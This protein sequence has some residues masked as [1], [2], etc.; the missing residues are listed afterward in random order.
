[1]N[2]V[3][4]P[5]LSLAHH[6]WKQHVQPTDFAMDM[7]CG[8][9]R[10]MA[11]L[12]HLLKQGLVYGLDIQAIALQK[13]KEF[14][15]HQ[16]IHEQ[17]YGLFLQSHAVPIEIPVPPR[18][19]VYNLGYLPGG[20]KSIVTT[21]ETTL[22]S[23][24]QSVRLLARDGALSITCY[25]GHEKGLLEEEQVLN[26]AAQLPSSTWRVCHHRWINRMKSP[27]LVWI[28]R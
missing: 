24:E 18:L 2:P 7:T 12:C 6:Y 3:F 5:H 15:V 26:W 10:D 28:T 8:N 4:S 9:G 23:L 16:N 17:T 14:L 19:I 20:V 21:G 22:V 25:P 27:S 13:T 11:F 1:M